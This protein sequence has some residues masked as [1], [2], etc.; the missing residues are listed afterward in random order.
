MTVSCRGGRCRPGPRPGA[1][2]SAARPWAWQLGRGTAAKTEIRSKL[3]R[4]RRRPGY[5]TYR[6]GE[7]PAGRRRSS[8]RARQRP[9]SRRPRHHIRRRLRRAARCIGDFAAAPA[10]R[11]RALSAIGCSLRGRAGPTWESERAAKGPRAAAGRWQM[12]RCL[13]AAPS[14][15]APGALA[16]RPGAGRSGA[17]ARARA[18]SSGGKMV[19]W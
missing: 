12:E 18:R 13:G 6:I 16:C 14:S 17:E 7:Y 8:L 4:S 10:Q 2:A 9:S 1:S 15:D 11:V 3:F 5:R 19:P